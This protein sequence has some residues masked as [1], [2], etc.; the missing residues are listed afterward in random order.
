MRTSIDQAEALQLL[1]RLVSIES[2]ADAP[3]REAAIGKYLVQ[4]FRDHGIDA[5]LLPV[6][7]ERANVVARLPGG[8]G[9]SL[10]LNG[11]L[12]T[13][14]AGSMSDAFEPKLRDGVLWGRGTCDMKGAIAAMAC[15]MSAMARD[16]RITRTGDLMFTGTVGEETGSVGV[17]A[18]MDAGVRTT[19]AIVGEP[20]SLRVGIAHKGACF[21]RIHLAGRGAHGSQPEEGVN[22]VSYASR[23][24]HALENDLRVRLAQRSHPLLGTSTVSVG[25]IRGGTQPNIVAETCTLDIDRR[26]LPHESGT[27]EEVDD[28]VKGICQGVDDLSW[29]IEELPETSVVP[30]R[31][32]GTSPDSPLVNEAR[33]A[34]RDQ[35]MDDGPVGVPYWTDGGHLASSGIETIILGPGDIAYAHGPR[36]HLSISELESAANLYLALAR[37]VMEAS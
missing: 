12:D 6:S 25:R 33:H 34:C 10:M 13:V 26:T 32:L 17:K 1:Q 27:L 30:H 20:T 35:G 4:W 16:E 8:N 7:G 18:L 36:E 11:H 19:Y 28:L 22:A 29:R 5:D 23:I 37:Y 9:P 15:A 14:P 21:V 2:H 24:V 31:A 3:D